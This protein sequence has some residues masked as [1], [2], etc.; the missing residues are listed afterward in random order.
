MASLDRPMKPFL[1]S[2]FRG[3]ERRLLLG[4]R[5]R[6]IL[7]G[8]KLEISFLMKESLATLC[9]CVLGRLL[10]FS[11]VRL[12]TAEVEGRKAVIIKVLSSSFKLA[13]FNPLYA[14]RL[15]LQ[16]PTQS[17]LHRC[18][19]NGTSDSNPP[20]ST[21]KR[22]AEMEM[23]SALS[24]RN[25]CTNDSNVTTCSTAVLGVGLSGVTTAINELKFSLI[26]DIS[27]R[28]RMLFTLKG[29]KWNKSRIYFLCSNIYWFV[30]LQFPRKASAMFS[31]Y[32]FI[33]ENHE[34]SSSWWLDRC[35]TFPFIAERIFVCQV[36]GN[37]HC[38]R[39]S[40]R[41]RKQIE[42]ETFVGI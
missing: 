12:E 11:S 17:F 24:I 31:L 16:K 9:W 1:A 18:D 30:A 38:L 33:S 42:L 36:G 13:R 8:G 22:I 6:P 3:K 4:R 21:T 14:K 19:L 20:Q 40:V 41:R 32:V 34:R 15:R 23:S 7:C 5:W 35:Q 2:F 25:K 39:K 37:F 26:K 28:K 10:F 27:T 29:M